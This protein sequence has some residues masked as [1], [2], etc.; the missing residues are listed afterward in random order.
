[1]SYR[2]DSILMHN[3][4]LFQSSPVHQHV[5]WKTSKF[6]KWVLFSY[7]NISLPVYWQERS[8]FLVPKCNERFWPKVPKEFFV[9]MFLPKACH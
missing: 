8:F 7:M 5:S 3:E 4:S 2:L 9:K 1:M 6:A